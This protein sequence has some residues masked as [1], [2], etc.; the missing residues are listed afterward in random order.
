MNRGDRI[1]AFH[2]LRFLSTHADVFFGCVADEPWDSS[3]IDALKP[4]CREI[5]VFRLHPQ[6]RWVRAAKN[7]AAGKSITAGAFFSP[8]LA[9]TVRRWSATTEFDAAVLFCSSMGTYHRFFKKRPRRILVDFVD[10][11][12]QK[13]LDYAASSNGLKKWLYRHEASRVKKLESHLSSSADAVAVVSEDEAQ[14]FGSHHA[15]VE[16]VAISNGV[17]HDFFSPHAICS[18]N[19]GNLKR[20]NPHLVFVG[21]LDYLPNVQGLEWFCAEVLPVLRKQFEQVSL[22]I[23]GRRPCPRVQALARHSEIRI[24]GEVDDVRPYV[25]AADAAI[26]PLKIARGIQNKVLEAL[27]CGKPVIA[28]REAATGIENFGGLFI[29]DNPDE[30]NQAL[31]SFGSPAAYTNACKAARSGIEQN[32]CWSAKLAPVLELLNL[33]E[34]QIISTLGGKPAEEELPDLSI[35]HS[36]R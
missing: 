17:D 7:L 27:A 30:W 36:Q 19:P 34:S 4:Y 29:A 16:A 3:H 15:N 28:T 20:G 14:I 5:A 1:R 18:E 13:W 8:Q 26:A 32:Y 23:V 6:W 22:D 2:L 31:Q 11:D 21:V 35:L 33:R 24:I 9:Q 10:V 12:S 25:L